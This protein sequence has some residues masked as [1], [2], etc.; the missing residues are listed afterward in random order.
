MTVYKHDMGQRPTPQSGFS[1]LNC[2]FREA[3]GATGLGSLGNAPWQS[4]AALDSGSNPVEAR[5]FQTSVKIAYQSSSNLMHRGLKATVI[6]KQC[7]HDSQKE[8]YKLRESDI[9][10]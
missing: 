5:W 4:I 10:S 6:R 1:Y 2:L 7:N 3:P 8:I 9:R